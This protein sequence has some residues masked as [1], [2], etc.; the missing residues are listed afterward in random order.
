MSSSNKTIKPFYIYTDDRCLFVKNI[1]E[2]HEKLAKNIFSYCANF[3][4]SNKIHIC[5]IDTS[6]K[7]VHFINNKGT[8]K[9]KVISKLLNNVKNIKDMRLYIYNNLL[10]IFITENYPLSDNLY[11]I[12]HINFDTSNY[13]VSK[14]NIN[15]VFKENEFI[16][17]INLDEL[18]NIILEY[19][20]KNNISR[21]ISNNLS[22]FN[23]TSRKWMPSNGLMRNSNK[24]L[25]NYN[26]ST[27]TNIKDDIFE[28]CYSIKYKL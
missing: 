28:Y 26:Y 1:N 4:E 16:Y 10:H 14:Y 11:K 13:K 21:N 20:T 19:K 8:W 7:L 22:I 3:D 5:A 27:Y 2:H 9:K 15:N 24:N 25:S 12:C 18:S 6:G 17:K 23:I